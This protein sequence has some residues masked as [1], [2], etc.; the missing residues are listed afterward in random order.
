MVL[1]DGVA[2][3]VRTWLFNAPENYGQAVASEFIV[4]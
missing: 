2:E 4:R 1:V 3:R